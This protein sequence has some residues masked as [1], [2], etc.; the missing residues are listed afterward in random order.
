MSDVL[1]VRPLRRPNQYVRNG[2]V[3]PF[4]ADL[5][6]GAIIKGVYL[7]GTAKYD[8][9]SPF[10]PSEHRGLSGEMIFHVAG[11]TYYPTNAGYVRLE[12]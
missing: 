1:Q 8:P 11:A 9:H 2:E 10:V 5:G 6:N 7:Y 12:K 4:E 3:K